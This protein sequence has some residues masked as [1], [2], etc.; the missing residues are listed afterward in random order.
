MRRATSEE[1]MLGQNSAVESQPIIRPA[2]E[3]GEN[4]NLNKSLSDKYGS[5]D[6]CNDTISWQGHL[7]RVM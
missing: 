7:D 6:Y 2:A 3:N 4:K 1:S 5:K